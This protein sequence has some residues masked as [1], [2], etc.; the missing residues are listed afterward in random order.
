M[1]DNPYFNNISMDNKKQEIL[2]TFMSEFC[3]FV[4]SSLTTVYLE[5][6]DNIYIIS[7]G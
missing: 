6:I 7:G 4:T 2:Q 1:L 5:L 3:L